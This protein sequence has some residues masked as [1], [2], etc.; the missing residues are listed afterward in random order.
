MVA[1]TKR[2]AAVK[3]RF[4]IVPSGK[5]G[6][7]R[8]FCQGQERLFPPDQISGSQGANRNYRDRNDRY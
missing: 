3:L 1:C 6:A 8:L 4:E 7:G 2:S 5:A